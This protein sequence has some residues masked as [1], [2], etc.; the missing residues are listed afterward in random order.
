MPPL[1]SIKKEKFARLIATKGISQAKAYQR[2]Y[3]DKCSPQVAAAGGSRLL[4]HGIVRNRVDEI[5]NEQG[6]KIEKEMLDLK[7]ITQATYPLVSGGI[8][9][10][11]YEDWSARNT[12]H[13]TLLRVRGALQ[14]QQTNI[15]NLNLDQDTAKQLITLV[16]NRQYDDK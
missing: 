13:N 5:L 1:K 10:G 12:A 16:S 3:N 6:Y 8:I 11:Q 14:D 4:R 2:A 15:L 9:L 7:E